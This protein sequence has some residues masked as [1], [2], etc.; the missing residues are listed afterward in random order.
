MI[1]AQNHLLRL[2]GNNYLLWVGLMLFFVSSCSASRKTQSEYLP[3]QKKKEVVIKEAEE[4]VYD[5]LKQ[6]KDQQQLKNPNRFKEQEYKI[7]VMLPF[8][9]N[10]QDAKNP[11]YALQQMVLQY[12]QGVLLALD[13]L[14]GLGLKAQVIVKDSERDSLKAVKIL[15]A[16]GMQ[17][18]DLIIG[19][20]DA[21]GFAYTSNFALANQIPIIAPFASAETK[22]FIDNP[23]AFYCNP[24]LSHY[25][26]HLVRHL[27]RKKQNRIIYVG[28]GS[29]TD[30]EL[31]AGLER[32]LKDSDIKI[33]KASQA[34]VVSFLNASSDSSNLVVIASDQESFSI[35]ITRILKANAEKFQIQAVGLDSWLSFREPD[36]THWDKLNLIL[37]SNFFEDKSLA[38]Y[39][40]FM[41]SFR[42]RHSEPPNE[43]AVKG[44]DHLLFFGTCLLTFGKEFPLYIRKTQFESTGTRFYFINTAKGNVNSHVNVLQFKQHRFIR[45]NE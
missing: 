12:Y 17:E 10:V 16:P 45:I 43:L 40:Q 5:K 33:V 39:H 21:P 41:N 23:F 2:S 42:L 28:D 35:N 38:S 31:L 26:D 6:E 14:K 13:S 15:S 8:M 29:N 20:L 24:V 22:G 36:F 25:S 19:P 34:N 27:I 44:F 7:L 11:D 4:P 32:A 37:L 18:L 30:K 3:N 1:S 9:L